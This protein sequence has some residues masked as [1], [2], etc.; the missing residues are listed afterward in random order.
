MKKLL[1]FTLGIGLG[2][3]V[4]VSV[5]ILLAPMPG[6]ELVARLKQ[7]WEETMDE[8]RRASELRRAELEAELAQMRGKTLPRLPPPGGTSR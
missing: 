2:A 8:A 3:M 1:S 5:V 7:G 6:S 4:G